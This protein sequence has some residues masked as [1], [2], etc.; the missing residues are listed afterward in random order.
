MRRLAPLAAVMTAV[1]MAG[2]GVACDSDEKPQT[3]VALAGQ[4]V[5]TAQL[6]SVAGGLCEAARQAATDVNAARQTFFGRSHEALHLI[7]RGLE[8]KDRA[9]SARLLEAKQRVEADF[10][11]AAPGAQV[12]ADLG[13]LAEIT[14]SS[15]DTFDVDADPC[16][17]A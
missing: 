5:T 17:P 1:L 2:A 10:T 14:R 4:T 16:S 7:A 12:A 11:G 3:V 13:R 8:E 9:E 6:R 15:L